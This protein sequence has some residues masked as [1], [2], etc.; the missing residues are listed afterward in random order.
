MKSEGGIS[1]SGWDHMWKKK[2]R[3]KKG[4]KKGKLGKT[5]NIKQNKINT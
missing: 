2:D 4:K 1:Y 5:R 3:M